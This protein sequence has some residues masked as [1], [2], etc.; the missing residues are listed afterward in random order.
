MWWAALLGSVGALREDRRDPTIFAN[1]EWLAEKGGTFGERAGA[2]RR[3]APAELQRIYETA[4]PGMVERI[5]MAEES[6]MLPERAGPPTDASTRSRS[7]RIRE[8]A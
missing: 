4:I 5:K 6:R 2:P 3:Y 8:R 7:R 1:F